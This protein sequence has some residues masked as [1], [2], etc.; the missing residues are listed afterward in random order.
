MVYHASAA[1]PYED[2]RDSQHSRIPRS[3]FA[4]LVD[5]QILQRCIPG[6]ES[7]EKTAEDTYVATMKAG[8]GAIKAPSKA[9]CVGTFAR[10]PITK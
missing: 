9:L 1:S 8:V 2:S 4:A 6:C 10:L 3:H 5:P 7:L